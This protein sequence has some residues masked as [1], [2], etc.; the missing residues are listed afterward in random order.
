MSSPF[1]ARFTGEGSGV[2]VGRERIS[3]YWQTALRNLPDLHF[4]LQG[5]FLGASS[6]VISYRTS[7]GGLATEVFFLNE[8]GLVFRAVA[9]YQSQE[10]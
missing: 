2:L 4:D 1:I 7:F 8:V 3:A 9:H 6:I 10:A 5:V